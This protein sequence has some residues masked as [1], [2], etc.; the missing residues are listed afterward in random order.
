MEA[1][2]IVCLIKTCLYLFKLST[3]FPTCIV[4]WPL[5]QNGE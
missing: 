1:E 5:A 4:N 2:I 3:K